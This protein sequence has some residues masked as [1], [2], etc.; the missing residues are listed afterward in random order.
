[1]PEVYVRIAAIGSVLI[2]LMIDASSLFMFVSL[3]FIGVRYVICQIGVFLWSVLVGTG[4]GLVFIAKYLL[5]MVVAAFV[6]WPFVLVIGALLAGAAWLALRYESLIPVAPE[7]KAKPEPEVLSLDE[8]KRLAT[9]RVAESI[10]SRLPSVVDKRGV[11]YTN[12]SPM[13]AEWLD[14]VVDPSWTTVHADL[15]GS[16]LVDSPEYAA[17]VDKIL[18]EF[19]A[20]EAAEQAKR[21]ARAAKCAAVTGAINRALT[22]IGRAI[23]WLFKQ[24]WVF[25][26]LLWELAKAKKSGACPYLVF[27]EPVTQ[28]PPTTP[29]PKA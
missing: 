22:P 21:D 13:V 7:P 16:K 28:T 14:K 24:S 29:A 17:I 20:K 11:E 9:K 27:S 10:Y 12:R 4:T 23:K 19:R 8:V 18:T 3:P 15:I 6:I 5:S 1:M 26:C 2:A 25:A